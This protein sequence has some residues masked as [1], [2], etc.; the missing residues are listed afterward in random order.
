MT[1]RPHFMAE[2][3]ARYRA[4]C[5]PADAGPAQVEHT[6]LAFFAGA[7][8]VYGVMLAVGDDTVSDERAEAIIDAVGRECHAVLST[9]AGALEAFGGTVRE[10]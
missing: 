2:Q 9:M 7:M 1:V 5:V 3:W 6:R 4:T 8:V 10:S